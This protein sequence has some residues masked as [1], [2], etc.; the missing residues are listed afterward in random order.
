M[1]RV[2]VLVALAAVVAVPF[3][4][5]AA[6]QAKPPLKGYE[7]Y[8]WHDEKKGWQFV[9][10]TGTNELK[11]EKQV[12]GAATIYTGSDKML[13]ALRQLPKG[14]SVGWYHNIKGFE[15]PPDSEL[16]SIREAAKAAGIDLRVPEK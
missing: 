10:M 1:T 16:K 9:V 15:Y 7:L 5:V 11:T 14:K 6:A 8:S 2:L 12:K 4:R 13:D 3:G